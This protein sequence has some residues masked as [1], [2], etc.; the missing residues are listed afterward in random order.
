MHE[1]L[2]PQP[3]GRPESESTHDRN[4]RVSFC[5]QQRHC[6]SVSG[7]HTDLAIQGGIVLLVSLTGI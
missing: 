2:L 6:V 7:I 5:H 3:A 4:Q 1:G